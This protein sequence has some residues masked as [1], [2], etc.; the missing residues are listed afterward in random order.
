[1]LFPPPPPP[2]PPLL[3]PSRLSVPSR[4]SCCDL[5]AIDETGAAARLLYHLNTQ[6]E[7]KWEEVPKEDPALSQA[8]V[9]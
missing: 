3:R 2:P 7:P 5:T 1:M 8:D 4:F 9:S 6:E